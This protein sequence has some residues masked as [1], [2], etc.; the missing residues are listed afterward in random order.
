MDRLL[1]TSIELP[2]KVPADTADST[3]IQAANTC[4]QWLQ[5]NQYSQLQAVS[6]NADYLIPQ[7]TVSESRLWGRTLSVLFQ[8]SLPGLE[9]SLGN[10]GGRQQKARI[11]QSK[12]QGQ[13]SAVRLWLDR[14]TS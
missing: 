14:V 2:H 10:R 6:W 7:T 9:F 12:V 11:C 13:D 3:I 8:V 4:C 5:R 1:L